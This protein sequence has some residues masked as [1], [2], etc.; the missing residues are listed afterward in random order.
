MADEINLA[1]GAYRAYAVVN[2]Q[3]LF[4]CSFQGGNFDFIANDQEAMMFRSLER[5]QALARSVNGDVVE[6][7]MSFERALPHQDGAR[8]QSSLAQL[9]NARAEEVKLQGACGADL[10]KQSKPP[11]I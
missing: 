4:L 10:P 5:A 8:M 6:F 11:R 7:S 3:N 2:E 1:P 9:A